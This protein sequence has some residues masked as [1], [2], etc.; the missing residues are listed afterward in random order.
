MMSTVFLICAVIGGTILVCQFV[1]TLVGFGHHD[2]DIGHDVSADVGAGDAADA[3]GGDLDGHDAQGQHHGSTWLFSV[4]SFRTLV[5]AATFF[6]LAGLASSSAG[7][8]SITQVAIA[9]VCGAAAMFATH[10][11]VRQFNR[12][13]EDGTVRINRAIGQEGTVYLTIPPGGSSTGKVQVKVQD[14]LM[15]YEA[16][17]VGDTPLNT[18]ARV[19]VVGIEGGKWLRV[20]PVREQIAAAAKS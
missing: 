12:L 17:T 6:G 8:S 4:V 18:G 13:S 11:T 7:L 9:V 20:E 10:W 2:L 5:A 16:V 15:E 1:L 3:H 14:R 19:V